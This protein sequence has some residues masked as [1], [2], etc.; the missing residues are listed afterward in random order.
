MN[1]GMKTS[2]KTSAKTS[3]RT[4]MKTSMKTSAKTSMKTLIGK[5]YASMLAI[6]LTV[7]LLLSGVPLMAFASGGSTAAAAGANVAQAMNVANVAQAMST[8]N[9]ADPINNQDTSDTSDSSGSSDPADANASPGEIANPN[10]NDESE[11]GDDFGVPDD[12]GGVQTDEDDT[13]DSQSGAGNN[14]SSQAEAENTDVSQTGEES[15]KDSQADAEDALD[16]NQDSND[17]DENFS[18]LS[19]PI[20]FGA[21]VSISSAMDVPDAKRL[22]V[23]AMSTT[24]GTALILYSQNVSVAQRFR[25]VGAGG[26]YFT[27]ES[28]A[29]GMVLD[30]CGGVAYAGASIIQ[31]PRLGASGSDNQKWALQSAGDNS[32][33]L[34]SK[35]DSRFCIDISGQSKQDG[36][37]VLLWPKSTNQANQRFFIKEF[38][39]SNIASNTALSLVSRA[40]GKLLDIRGASTSDGANALI[41]PGTGGMNQ[42]F[43]FNYDSSTGYY[44]IISLSS[45]KALDVKAASASAG[46]EVIQWQQHNGFNQW[47]ALSYDTLTSSY[48]IQ[49]ANSGL[50]LDVRGGSTSDGAEVITWAA[51]GGDNQKW[52]IRKAF[53]PDGYYSFASKL[54]GNFRLGIKNAS[55]NNDAPL[56]LANYVDAVEQKFRVRNFMDG[57]AMIIAMGSGMAIDVNKGI[58][59]F[60]SSAIQYTADQSNS[61]QRWIIEFENDGSISFVS[62][63]QGARAAITVVD[64]NGTYAF[65]ATNG[66]NCAV[67]DKNGYAAQAFIPQRIDVPLGFGSY[68]RLDGIDVSGWQPANIGELVS[69]D[70][71]IVKSTQGTWFTNSLYTQQANSALWRGKKLGFYHFAEDGTD[72]KEEARHFVSKIEGYVGNALLFLDYEADALQNGRE[73][74]RTFMREVK[75]LTG[76][77]CGV[78]CAAYEADVQDIPELCREEGAIYWTANYRYGYTRLD[79]YSQ[80]ITPMLPANIYQYTSTGYLPGYDK[81]LDF[82][83][84]YGTVADW[85]YFAKH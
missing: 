47:W 53:L 57:S 83:V 29:S 31:W 49:A 80:D 81:P 12:I 17:D 78:Y 75:R 38:A 52:I 36:T 69:Y 28:I 11:T 21:A 42:R 14:A 70:F 40:S 68:E 6:V 1:V 61:N 76:V 60:G 71:M 37:A 8:V 79:G 10:A 85:D 56:E 65:A 15:T 54:D 64:N 32:Y 30:V 35:L 24:A 13:V 58:I 50:C 34:V 23:P 19:L 82:N 55:I 2:A 67:L 43:S 22:D 25:L 51:N 26:N 41:W 77:S 45:Y 46:S 72:A 84:F 3:M 18:T 5:Y 4:S 62:V 48:I 66:S 59:G 16:P 7:A 74:V 27:I 73:W 9:V 44:T 39:A 33:F 63:L 20:S